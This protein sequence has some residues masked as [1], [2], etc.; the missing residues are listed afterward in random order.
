M[1]AWLQMRTEER[2]SA[3]A[4]YTV[5]NLSLRSMSMSSCSIY[6]ATLG[7]SRWEPSHSLLLLGREGKRTSTHASWSEALHITSASACQHLTCKVSCLQLYC[8]AA[9]DLSRALVQTHVLFIVL[10]WHTVSDRWWGDIYCITI[11]WLSII[12]L[13]MQS[14]VVMQWHHLSLWSVLWWCRNK[15]QSI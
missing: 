8:L 6:R 1:P 10:G 4:E 14:V 7:S 12:T 2:G 3:V 11:C 5:F 15:C 9:V 13:R